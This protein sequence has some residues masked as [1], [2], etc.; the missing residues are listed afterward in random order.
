M[1]VA[2]DA[3]FHA[4]EPGQTTWAETIGLWFAV[5]EE[6]LY[7]NVYLL[8]R[9]EVGA[10]ICAINAVQG[11]CREPYEVD[12]TDPRMH[13]PC[14]PSMADFTLDNG[15][16]MRAERPPTDYRIRY[17]AESGACRL[18]LDLTGAMPAWDPHDPADNPLTAGHDTDLGL[19]DAWSR[20]HLDFVGRTRGELVLRGRRYAVDA[21]AGMDRSWGPRAELGRTAVS[22]LHVPF[23]EDLGAH[24][25]MTVA[26]DGG[27]VVYP[28]LRFGY[29][30]DADG[31]S[32]VV[33][34]TMESEHRGLVPSA[35]RITVTDA[36]GRRLELVGEAVA[37]APW[38]TFSPAYATFQSLM[39]YELDGRVAHGLMSEVWGIEYLA[40][41]TSRHGRV[42]HQA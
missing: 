31:V 27:R 33:A 37:S 6:R 29:V 24:L 16:S 23:G 38:Y 25:V 3:D 12:F 8:A 40:A 42:A 14:P 34:A 32:G 20:G 4:H 19:G 18:D 41:R 30:Y 1:I 22:Y 10:T 13:V 21:M 39:R 26:L 17:Q 2:A 35:T 15:L 36:R 28:S 7:G 5:P 11:H 9:P